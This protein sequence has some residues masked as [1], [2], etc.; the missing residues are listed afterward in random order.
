MEALRA[1]TG[2]VGLLGASAR[3]VTLANIGELA[4]CVTE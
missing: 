1:G 3:K 2:A 4:K